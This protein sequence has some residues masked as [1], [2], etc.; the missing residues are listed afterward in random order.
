MSK[1][2]K[3]YEILAE[4][5]N[6]KKPC[7]GPHWRMKAPKQSLLHIYIWNAVNSTYNRQIYAFHTDA[8]TKN[9]HRMMPAGVQLPWPG[10]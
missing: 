3:L 5:C 6:I 8:H 4:S 9:P 2:I 1:S 7:G 10:K